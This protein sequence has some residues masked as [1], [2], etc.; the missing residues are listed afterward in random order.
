MI[1]S[2]FRTLALFL[3]VAAFSFAANGP[4]WA[5]ALNFDDTAAND[6]ITVS[7]NDFEFGS[8]LNGQPFQQGL[9]NP[10]SAV[11]KESDGAISFTG[12]WITNGQQPPDSQTVYL[13]E[14]PFN[15]GTAPLVSDIF[16]YSIIPNTANGTATIDAT[17][18]SDFEDNLGFLPA[19]ADPRFVFVETGQPINLSF[20]ALSISIASDVEVPEPSTFV[21]LGF[22]LVGALGY[23]VRRKRFA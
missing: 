10:A 3:L 2:T 21:L 22:A 14:S 15:P 11:V 8:S 7:A 18:V 23:C 19:N 6:T 17:F 5:A 13:I 12:T 1:T 16:R 20:L 9:N 4:L